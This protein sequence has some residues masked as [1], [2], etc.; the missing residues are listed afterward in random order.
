MVQ[1]YADP[2]LTV[3]WPNGAVG[4]RSSA[5]PNDPLGPFAKV[6]NC[7]I[8]GTDI[9]LTCYAT[10]YADTFFSIPAETKYRGKRVVGYFTMNEDILEFRV[11]NTHK[12]LFPGLT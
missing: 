2:N 1:F 3:T 11:M 6:E 4:Y 7:P 5:P 12:H 9:R 10:G 8:A